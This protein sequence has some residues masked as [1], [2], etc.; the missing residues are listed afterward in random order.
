MK[1]AILHIASLCADIQTNTQSLLK[2]CEQAK[3]AGVRLLLTP[4]L[5]LC[6]MPLGDLLNHDSSSY[7]HLT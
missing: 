5:I 2:G 6:G 3:Q 4:E 1:I 7:I